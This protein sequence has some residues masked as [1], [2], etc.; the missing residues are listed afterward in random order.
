MTKLDI[1]CLIKTIK[2]YF[3]DKDFKSLTLS[4]Y[5]GKNITI[6]QITDLKSVALHVSIYRY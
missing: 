3:Y 2:R 6:L 1:T 5:Y 4:I